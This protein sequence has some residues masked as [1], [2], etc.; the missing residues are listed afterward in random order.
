MMILRCRMHL[1]GPRRFAWRRP[2]VAAMSHM[3]HPR[4]V[5]H[6]IL[7]FVLLGLAIVFLSGPVIAV[8]AILFSVAFAIVSPLLPFALIG[9]LVWLPFRLLKVGKTAA[10]SDVHYKAGVICKTAFAGPVQTAAGVCKQAVSRSHEC[11]ERARLTAYNLGAFF[12]EVICGAA[13]GAL[14]GYLVTYD[15]EAKHVA[16][17]PIIIAAMAGALLGI[18]VGL[19]RFQGCHTEPAQVL[20]DR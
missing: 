14:F 6:K 11:A 8:V 1:R 5:A 2:E 12:C 19:S 17:D 9:F 13:V 18:G 20:A 16:E 4:T 10:W 15:P 3:H 7:A